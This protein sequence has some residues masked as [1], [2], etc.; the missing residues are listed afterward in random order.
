PVDPFSLGELA[1][2]GSL[3]VTRPSLATYT[4]TR[5]EL[6]KSA[7]AL[8]KMVTAGKITI[9]INQTYPLKEAPQAHRD[10]E[11]RKTTGSTV[12]LP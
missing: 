11:G 3:Y 5:E 10:L 7:K 6:E 1:S 8:F 12:L 2:R 9:E 4:S